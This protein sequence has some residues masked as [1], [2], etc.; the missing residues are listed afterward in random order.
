[1]H[2]IVG[3]SVD[4][5]VEDSEIDD[6][7]SYLYMPVNDKRPLYFREAIIIFNKEPVIILNT[8]DVLKPDQL[9]VEV[10]IN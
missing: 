2:E 9:N 6:I 10:S 8:N 5:I 3:I 4:E 1:M 7:M